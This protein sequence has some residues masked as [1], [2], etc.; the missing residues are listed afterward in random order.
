MQPTS[1]HRSDRN[2]GLQEGVTLEEPLVA[3]D[4]PMLAGEPGGSVLRA[5]PD[6]LLTSPSGRPRTGA[7]NLAMWA[8]PLAIL[9]GLLAV[10]FMRSNQHLPNDGRVR[11][12]IDNAQQIAPA[13]NNL[14]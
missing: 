6:A 12:P 2:L 14:R 1:P 3:Q 7:R 4:T 8:L 9:A 10:A 11:G 5:D 13:G